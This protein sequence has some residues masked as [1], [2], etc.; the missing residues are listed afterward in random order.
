MKLPKLNID[1]AS[2]IM[3]LNDCTEA[4]EPVLTCSLAKEDIERFRDNPM[5]VPKYCLHTQG[6]ERAVKE[7][8]QASESVYGFERR[9]GFIQ[10]R[11]ENRSLM[12]SLDTKMSLENLVKI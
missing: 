2:T 12:S 3:D 6:I 7:V 9:D 5:N 4:R 10:G 8:T 1:I 11:A